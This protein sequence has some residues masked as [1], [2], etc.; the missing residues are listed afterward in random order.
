MPV[1]ILFSLFLPAPL[2]AFPLAAL[3]I[4]SRVRTRTEAVVAGLAG[5]VSMGWLLFPGDLPDQV[6]RAGLLITT[7]LFIV[8][9]R[10]REWSFTHRALTSIGA[11]AAVLVILFVVLGRS[12]DEL[13]W[14]VL[15][16]R[17]RDAGLAMTPLRASDPE[18]ARSFEAILAR[19]IA[20]EADNFA[21]VTGLKLLAGLAL[22]TSIYCRV[23][24][25]P[26]G[27]P[28]GRFR[29]F[30]FTEHLGWAAVIPLLIVLLP[31]L[32]QAK[33]AASNVLLMTGI[34]YALRGLAVAAFVAGLAGTGPLGVVLA[35]TASL[36]MLPVVAGVGILLGVLDT[37][38]D[39]RKRWS[40]PPP[41]S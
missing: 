24:A 11:A 12:W 39:L 29:D 9:A 40:V 21:A 16:Q 3:L 6:L 38:M 19:S 34:L 22:A 28:L 20:F 32:L 23:A 33:I 15:F 41:E 36:L 14:A 18:V 30:R 5:A 26:V 8:L 13:H 31:G 10:S 17:T 27:A 4:V 25:Q 2:F 7:I 37:G 35:V 1:A